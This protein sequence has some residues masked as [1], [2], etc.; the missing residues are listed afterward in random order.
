MKVIHSDKAPVAVGPYSQGIEVNGLL[1]FSGMLP[2]NPKASEIEAKD[3]VGQTTQVLENISALLDSQG[4]SLK[5][6]VKTTIFLDSMDD[7]AEVNKVYGTYFSEHK[8][9][10]SCVAVQDIPKGAL[11]EIEIIASTLGGA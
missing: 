10:R 7:F 1:F 9:A 5:N 6:V 8:P 4:L 11:V 3:I 2:I